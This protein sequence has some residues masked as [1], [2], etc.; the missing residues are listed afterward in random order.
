MVEREEEERNK[1]R[2]GGKPLVPA[3]HWLPIKYKSIN[4]QNMDNY[5][6]PCLNHIKISGTVLLAK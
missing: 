4:P 5:L 6:F 1:R 2:K 3:T